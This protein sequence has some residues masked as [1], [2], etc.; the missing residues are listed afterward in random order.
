MEVDSASMCPSTV[1]FSSHF[2]LSTCPV[3]GDFFPI[4]G[5][6]GLAHPTIRSPVDGYVG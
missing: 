2:A 1:Y 4:Q 5:P 6:S 3:C